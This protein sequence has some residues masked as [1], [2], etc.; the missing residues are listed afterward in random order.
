MRYVVAI[1]QG[2]T[3]TTVLV[4]DRELHVVGR[5]TREFPQVYPQPGWV[6]HDPEAIWNSVTESLGAA[7]SD[8]GIRGEEVAAL[9]ITNQRETTVLWERASLRPVRNAIVWQDRRTAEMCARL[10]REGAE[11]QVR[12]KTGLFFDPY[13]SG[14]KLRWMLDEDP[15]RRRGAEDGSLCF[16]TVDSYLVARLSDGGAH[17]TDVTNA[18]RTLF[19]DLRTLDW[20]D[21]LLAVLEVPRALLP[22]VRSSSEVYAET[23][24]VPGLPDG[25]PI[26]G[27]AGDQQAALFGQACYE[28]GAAK[29]TYGTGAFLLMNTGD[30]IVASK[31]GL[32]TTVAWKLGT[33]AEAGE[34]R[35]A[36]EGSAFVAGAVVQWLRDQLG[37]FSS[38]AEIEALAASVE[39]AGEVIVVPAH[40]GLGAPHWRPDARGLITGL[41]RGSTR[42]HIARAALDGVALQNYD[43]L[44]AMERDSGRELASLKVDGGASANDLLMQFQSDVLGVSIARPEILETTALGSAFLAGLATSVWADKAEIAAAWREAKRFEPKADRT[45]IDAHLERWNEA[46]AKA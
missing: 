12:A 29:C 15:T 26:A 10:K 34:V 24:G 22:E 45:V 25:I 38:A 37:F 40:A 17:I 33:G 31:S 39:D 3:G 32:V 13:F 28:A 1:D 43:I 21:E 27:I 6:E 41:T 11:E 19:M 23:R 5:A 46:V 7:L 35:Y 20:D 8:A 36:L 18:S 16:G 44:K 30:E 14:T 4:L 42:A 9:G 2:T